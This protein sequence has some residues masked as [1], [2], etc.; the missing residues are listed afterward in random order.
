MDKPDWNKV[1]VIL[2]PQAGQ[3][4][5][6]SPLFSEMLGIPVRK[7]SGPDGRIAEGNEIIRE[8]AA[9]GIEAELYLTQG[10]NDGTAR[11]ASAAADGYDLVIAAGGDGTINEV[12]NGL[13]GTQTALGV[14]PLGTVN[15]LGI[16]LGL[17]PYIGECCRIIARGETRPVDLGRIERRYFIT[18]AGIGFDAQV[19]RKTTRGIK[20]IFGALA[21][22]L[23]AVKQFFTWRFR[24]I[25]L[26]LDDQP[27]P[28]R[29][30]FVLIGNARYY[31]GRL[32]IASGADMSDGYLDIC[33]FK[34]RNLFRVLSYFLGMRWGRI[35]RDMSVEYF[36]CKK[37]RV[38]KNGRHPIHADAEYVCR[39]PAD[40]EVVPGA[41]KLVVPERL[42]TS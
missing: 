5:P 9:C 30:Y 25:R 2:N 12:V 32:V 10:E 31:G 41:L 4:A 11:A 21:Y 24:M 26:K 29:G 17:P 22:V 27:I 36:Q 42:T 37:I 28:R 13:A 8:L 7:G 33:I 14:I 1:L 20:R 39:S 6:L 40:I 15:V 18:M 16:E 34:H 23:V 38:L 3:S 35:E 19:I